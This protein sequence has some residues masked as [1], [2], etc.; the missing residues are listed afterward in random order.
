MRLRT[1][2]VLQLAALFLALGAS[3]LAQ[4]AYLYVVHALPGRDLADNLNP[5]LP[6]DILIDGKSCLTHSLTFGN[7]TSPYTLAAG[8]YEVQ[9]SLANT[10]APCTNPAVLDSQVTLTAGESITAVAAIS[11]TQPVLQLFTENLVSVVPGNARFVFVNSADAPAL[12]ATLIQVGVK[13]PLTFTGSANPGAQT[14]I[15]VPAGEYLIQ[16]TEVGSTNVLTSQTMSLADQSIVFSYASGETLN[17]TV[18]LVNRTV[19]DVF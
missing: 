3:A 4:N 12:E 8:T 9:I 5:Q 16:I 7:T 1:R 15:P 11:S 17:K 19:R 10:L 2:V 18:Q 13:N 6:V 14:Y